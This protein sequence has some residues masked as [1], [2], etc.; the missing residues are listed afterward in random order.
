M[1]FY[2][3]FDG[4]PEFSMVFRW[5]KSKKEKLKLVM[6][7][8]FEAL[9]ANHASLF[10]LNL[11]NLILVNTRKSTLSLEQ[12]VTSVVKDGMDLFV[13]LKQLPVP[14][15]RRR[16][17]MHPPVSLASSISSVHQK[18]PGMFVKNG[19][20]TCTKS[21]SEVEL[22]ESKISEK[23][24]TSFCL[25]DLRK[26]MGTLRNAARICA[27]ALSVD[28]EN[29]SPLSCLAEIYLEAGRPQIALEYIELA[30][31]V[32]STDSSL[33]F[34]HG[35]CLAAVGKL[36]EASNAYVKYMS[37]L[38]SLGA[39]Q[40]EI[41][42][43]QAAIAKVCAKSGN[44]KMAIDLF[45]NVL[46]E[47]STH[48]ESLKGFAIHTAGT[49]QDDLQEA[50]V[51]LL[52]LLVQSGGQHQHDVRKELANLMSSPGGMG[53]FEDQLSEVWRT[54]ES[55][56]FIADI[57]REWGA[58]KET[59]QLVLR[60]YELSP[61]DPGI[62]LYLVHTYEIL[63]K[64]NEAFLEAR[65]FLIRNGNLQIGRVS[66]SYFIPVLQLI[67]EEIYLNNTTLCIPPDFENQENI[68][69][70]L[71]SEFQQ[72]GLLFTLVKIL[73]V[74]GALNS[75][76]AFIPVLDKLHKDRGLHLTLLRNEA[77]FFSCISLVMEV[78][79]SPLPQNP[80]FIYF[81]SDS[82]CISPAWRTINYQEK[83]HVIH[84]LLAT[85]VK[86]WHIRKE[87]SFY[88]KFALLNALKEVPNDSTVI[89]NIGEIDCREGLLRAVD[90]CNYDS[91]E[92]AIETI[93]SIYID[94]LKEQNERHGFVTFVHP[95]LPVLKETRNVVLQFNEKLK[96]AVESCSGLQWLEL[97]D[98][99]LAKQT[100]EFN[101]EY[102]LDGTHVHPKYVSLLE[103]ALK[104]S[105]KDV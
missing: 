92:E 14:K 34:I 95:L 102:H 18:G 7:I 33:C 12:D 100:C 22:N 16:I 19:E 87:S 91:V 74:K 57:L 56:M 82:H 1:K 26:K 15:E 51:I 69:K 31:H 59:L 54:S 2:V 46:K 97:L 17:V 36:E 10:E 55:L 104:D 61:H 66:C 62:C 47:D 30:I 77:A 70:A 11:E 40:H 75:T 103:K 21:S 86:I 98:V 85:G 50:I 52:S 68:G 65:S 84:P 79:F 44:I 76:K 72:L 42:D 64:H 99:L 41:H 73:F 25:N 37:H 20:P 43:V 23:T 3:H 6:D 5:N 58:L 32:N 89:F 67:T 9:K 45:S 35:N 8:F 88:P 96:E 53:V 24:K 90:K 83:P 78:P 49:S 81:A 48:M 38:E 80:D 27:E 101:S 63:S 60:A 4:P 29:S 13:V 93:V 71:D 28:E 105:L 39:S 94:F